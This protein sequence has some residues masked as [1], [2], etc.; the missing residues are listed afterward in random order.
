MNVSRL[1]AGILT[2]AVALVPADG[3]TPLGSAFTYQGLLKRSGDPVNDT[4]D[5]EFS[6]WDAESGGNMVASPTPCNGIGVL[7]GLFTVQLDFGLTSFNGQ[8]RWLQVAVRSP[9]GGGSFTT[10][11]PRQPVTPTPYA[12]QTRGMVVGLD[13]ADF[14]VAD[15]RAF[16]LEFAGPPAEP[17]PNLIGGFVNN[18]V[19]PGVAGATIGGGGGGGSG[20]ENRV[21]DDFGTVGGGTGNT[22]GNSYA[23][24]TGTN[25]EVGG[26][27]GNTASGYGSTVSGGVSNT[28]SGFYAAVGGGHSNTASGHAS[29]IAGGETN[30]ASGS[31][32]AVGGGLDNRATGQHGTVAGGEENTASGLTTAT[33]GGGGQNT[34]SNVGSTVP[35]GGLNTA[36]GWYSFAAGYRA[37]ANHNGTFVW[38]DYTEADFASTAAN[39]FLIRADK[40]G[41]G[42]ASP[43]QKLSVAGAVHAQGGIITDEGTSGGGTRIGDV[44]TLSSVTLVTVY[45]GSLTWDATN[46][47]VKLR[48]TAGAYIHFAGHKNEGAGGS[49][50]SGYVLPNVTSVLATLNTNG[51]YLVVDVAHRDGRGHCH[52]YCYYDNGSLVANYTYRYD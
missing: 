37:K 48:E 26:G 30:T 31:W 41:I 36:A 35:G 34:A 2:T 49:F 21:V 22:A 51:E 20:M 42:T 32:S 47:Q 25:S 3:Q 17:G 23:P 40:V 5:F 11:S 52:L 7:D 28:A 8:A 33:V 9:A 10:L 13:Q 1:L 16:R 39:Q 29:A 43:S 45:G 12:L 15:A 46:F 38:G 19:R 44:K 50:I 27:S 18:S 24:G 6:L 14:F 4:A